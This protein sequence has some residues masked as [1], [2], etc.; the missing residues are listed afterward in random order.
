MQ[1]RLIGKFRAFSVEE[2]AMVDADK[3]QE[4]TAGTITAMKGCHNTTITRNIESEIRLEKCKTMYRS[5]KVYERFKSLIVKQAIDVQQTAFTIE[6]RL[7]L[8]VGTRKMQRIL[9]AMSTNN[10]TT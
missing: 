7:R 6:R 1:T 5:P 2:K 10:T 8:G 3:Q 9:K 4:M